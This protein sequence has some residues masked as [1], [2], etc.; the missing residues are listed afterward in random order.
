MKKF[1]AT[2]IL[3]LSS[4][5]VIFTAPLFTKK[6][7]F[8]GKGVMSDWGISYKVDGG[9]EEQVVVPPT[10]FKMDI[11]FQKDVVF[12]TTKPNTSFRINKDGTV[13]KLFAKFGMPAWEMLVV[14]GNEKRQSLVPVPP[15]YYFPEDRIREWNP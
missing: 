4:S 10:D 11:L 8:V 6:V 9:K 14:W 3:F 7:T 5:S 2:F 15:E 12:Y 1:L 13:V